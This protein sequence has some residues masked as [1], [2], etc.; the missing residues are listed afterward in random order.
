MTSLQNIGGGGG[1]GGGGVHP[2]ASPL[3]GPLIRVIRE[4]SNC[5]ISQVC[6]AGSIEVGITVT[7]EIGFV[8]GK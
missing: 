4:C 3:S 2:L 5:D 8:K 1:G 6:T 7:W